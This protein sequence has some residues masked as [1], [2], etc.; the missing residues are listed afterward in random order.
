MKI[1]Q[2]NNQTRIGSLE[3]PKEIKL[4]SLEPGIISLLLEISS[5]GL[6]LYKHLK[7][8]NLF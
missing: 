3:M 4:R 7:L 8:L 2:C 6:V 5:R 1:K